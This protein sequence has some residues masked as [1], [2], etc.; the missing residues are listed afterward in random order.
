VAWRVSRAQQ[1]RDPWGRS[2]ALG[3]VEF[4]A[5]FEP[6]GVGW[7]LRGDPILA[8]ELH[9]GDSDARRAYWDSLDE[10][11]WHERMRGAA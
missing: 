5:T 10:Q 11:E 3:A 2:R 4:E 6:V 9:E 1:R 7:S 8:A